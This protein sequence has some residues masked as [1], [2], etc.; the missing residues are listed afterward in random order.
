MYFLPVVNQKKNLKSY[1]EH[2][3]DFEN[4]VHTLAKENLIRT[5]EEQNEFEVDYT[6]STLNQKLNEPGLK[7][8]ILYTC[9]LGKDLKIQLVAEDD[10][11]SGQLN[12]NQEDKGERV[13][14]R[15][16][17]SQNPKQGLYVVEEVSESQEILSEYAE[18]KI[19]ALQEIS[20]GKNSH[21]LNHHQGDQSHDKHPD[22]FMLYSQSQLQKISEAMCEAK[23]DLFRPNVDA[24]R[25]FLEFNPDHYLEKGSRYEA[26]KIGID[27]H[28]LSL[29]E[30]IIKDMLKDKKLKRQIKD[31]V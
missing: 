17:L 13:I 1:T 22:E 4:G 24:Q 6:L 11:N 2:S 12:S 15:P 27:A 18:S 23:R 29:R 5:K 14:V 7:G 31:V 21:S 3:G 26:I 8:M 9:E 28:R 25:I 19:H 16:N 30:E 10:S 20:K